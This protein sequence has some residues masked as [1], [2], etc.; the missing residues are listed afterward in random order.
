MI[1]KPINLFFLAILTI[2]AL[3]GCGGSDYTIELPEQNQRYLDSLP[4][5]LKISYVSAPPTVVMLNG[6]DITEYFSDEDG[7][8]SASGSVVD[9]LLNQG[10]NVLSVEPGK[11]GPRRNFFMDTEGPRISIYEVESDGLVT[12]RGQLSDP[13]G[14]S[15]LTI[16]GEVA[17]IDGNDEFSVQVSNSDTYHL[18]ALDMD[19]RQSEVFYSDRNHIVDDAIKV[20][21]DESAIHDMLP[22][23]QEAVAGMDLNVALAQSGASTLFREEVGIH[24]PRV[25]LVPQVCTPKVCTF[26][27]CTPQICTPEVGVGPVDIRLLELEAS[28]VD[29]DVRELNID[30]LDVAEGHDWAFGD[31]EGITFDGEVLD[32]HLGIQIRSYVFGL[33]DVATTMLNVLGLSSLLDPL[34]GNFTV[35][36]DIS[37]LRASADVAISA[38]DGAT[39]A[40]IVSINAIGLG[41]LDSDFS[42]DV[43]LPSA[44]NLFGFGLAQAVVDSITAGIEGAKNLIFDLI[45]G[46]LLPPLADIIVDS[47]I[48]EIRINIAAG[49]SSG[50][51]LSTLFE[52]SDIDV[53]NDANSLL[54]SLNARVGAEAA[55]VS[56]G[57]IDT[58]SD[59]G[60]PEVIWV[61]DHFLPDQQS[62]PE[63]LGPA[64]DIAAKALGFSFTPNTIPD[65]ANDDSE[66]AIV[67]ATNFINQAMLALYESG[68]SH[69][70]L[71]LVIEN[72]AIITAT[73]ETATHRVLNEPAS[74]FELAFRGSVN[75][76][77]YLIINH[78]HIVTQEKSNT[79]EWSEV[80]DIELSADIPVN[81]EME[82]GHL[83]IALLTP[84]ISLNGVGGNNLLAQYILSTIV[85]EQLNLGLAQIPLPLMADITIGEETLVITPQNIDASDSAGIG[86]TANTQ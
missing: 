76:V 69:V 42:I 46:Q 38:H 47:M 36:T 20:R 82:E 14:A 15:D 70:K 66:I 32:T 39:D 71:P 83:K 30:R 75:K 25:V 86:I 68:I 27:I 22:I 37:R 21:I 48:S 28:L 12:I 6:V 79:D 3:L 67:A 19:G 16:N 65:V 78:F 41:D 62:I 24:F 11:F 51:Q 64:P 7:Y 18:V 84:T 13:S 49:I 52:V 50:A 35:H 23:A 59:F 9:G 45:F 4:D 26:G 57:D 31:W 74:P 33:T 29:V 61:N 58:A 17:S 72:N 80:Q 10:D 54:L 73:E 5:T 40:T 81:L 1:K 55:D 43:S 60:S 44:F 85:V 2:T 56:P 77:P 34:D 63:N 8:F 53:I